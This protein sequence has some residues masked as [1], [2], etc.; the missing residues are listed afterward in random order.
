MTLEY[1][2][3]VKK[4]F[5]KTI[6]LSEL[7]TRYIQSSS[8]SN[9][10][11]LNTYTQTE[12]DLA[13]A[14]T[15]KHSHSNISALDSVSGVNTGDQDLSGYALTSALHSAVTLGI[16]TASALS[17]SGQ[18]LSLGDVFVQNGGDTMTGE[19]QISKT[20]R[21][22]RLLYDST[23]YADFEVNSEGRMIFTN[24]AKIAVFE[25]TEFQISRPGGTNLGVFKVFQ[26]GNPAQSFEFSSQGN[27][28]WGDGISGV[29]TGMYRKG[30][31]LLQISNELW[32]GDFGA[33]DI[34]LGYNNQTIFNLQNKDMDFRVDGNTQDSVLHVDASTNRVGIGTATPSNKFDVAG[35]L[36]ADQILVGN[37][38]VDKDLTVSTDGTSTSFRV[39]NRQ[40][41]G[42]GWVTFDFAADNYSAF[43]DFQ[44]LS[45]AAHIRVD[46][47]KVISANN[48]TLGF[49]GVSPVS[50]QVL[51]TGAGATIDNVITALQ[52]LGL[53]SQ[54]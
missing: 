54:S 7:D 48:G 8:L 2:P 49:Y 10:S 4:G 6:S 33:E 21:Q 5:D 11:L 25:D 26:N 39:Q 35:A 3:L 50:R 30:A 41:G 52:N 13:D 14:V 16:N 51:A 23:H 42:S 27:L 40:S 37:G 44:N 46:G 45:D 32:L 12:V 31:A 38:S 1:N 29:D 28:N 34:R 24:T 53:V 22:M 47:T 20:T 9:I 43:M 19:L 18:Q 17:L 36:R 15:K